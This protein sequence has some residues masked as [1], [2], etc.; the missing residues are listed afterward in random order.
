MT[1]T[2]E[3]LKAQ[4][5]HPNVSAFARCVRSA[6]SNNRDDGSAYRTIFGGELIDDLSCHPRIAR[7][8][9]WGWTS[10]AGAYQAMCAVPG[11]VQTDTWGDFCRDMGV[12]VD[13]MP[14]DQPTQNAFLVWCVRRRNAL[15][16]VLDGDLEK[17]VD[18][19]SYEWA[20]FPPGRY[21]QPTTTID[22]LRAVFLQYGGRLSNADLI[23]P[24]APIEERDLSGIPP[25][26]EPEAPMPEES[27]SFDWSSALKVGGA[28]ASFFN[29]I[30]GVAISALGPLVEQKIEKA[31]GR[32]TDPAT[33]KTVAAQLSSVIESSLTKVTGKA[34]P[35]AAVAEIR[36]SPAAAA[37]VSAAVEQKLVDMTPLLNEMHRQA[38][39][40]F[41][42]EAAD[43]NDASVRV[44]K[45]GWNIQKYLVVGGLAVT[46][47]IV[48]ALL[49]VL[50]VQVSTAANHLPDATLI[51]FAGPLLVLAM[52]GL[53]E[54]YSFAFGGTQEGSP[55]AI[56]KGAKQ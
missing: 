1:L 25:R 10:A 28:I 20:S 50:I 39:E 53:R 16:A 29:P 37:A 52:Q 19:C 15:Q 38:Q 11:R 26:V 6:E 42:A 43:R 36:A 30:V 49:A 35:V 34:D 8:S 32:H 46:G 14:F 3:G 44:A 2:L 54:A 24:A 9:K 27:P 55:A 17:A 51:A 47:V 31:V 5:Q 56:A 7:Q 33:A 45:V 40:R 22:K 23:K 18:L 4:F 13:A 41:A 12:P 48:T 21:G